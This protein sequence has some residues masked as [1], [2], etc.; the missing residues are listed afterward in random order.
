MKELID[1]DIE[2]FIGRYSIGRDSNPMNQT[3]STHFLRVKVPGGFLTTKQLRGIANLTKKYSRSHAEITNRQSIQ[4]HW[5]DANDAL[6]IFS[7]MEKLG[8]TTDMC[9]QSFKGARHGDARN[10]VCCPVSGI[11]K[12]ELLNGQPLM[13]KLTNFFIGNPDF[14]DLPKKFKFSI[15]GCRSDC[16]HAIINDFS[17]VAVKKREQIGYAALVGGGMGASLPGPRM[18]RSAGIFINPKDA[19]EVAVAAIEIHRDYGNRETKMKARFKW[20]LDD[21]GLQKFLRVLESKLGKSFEKYKGPIFTK[22]NCHYGVQVQKQ[23]AHYHI[24]IPLLGGFL[25]SNQMINLADVVDKYGSGELNFTCKQNIILPNIQDKK[26]VLKHLEDIGF[27]LQVSRLQWSSQ[28]CAS[29]FCGKTKS[30]HAKQ[31]VKEI[32][33]YLES[34]YTK[35][36]LDEAKFAIYTSGCR[37]NCCSNLLSE[38]G[39]RGSLRKNEKGELEQNY[40]ILLQSNCK[41][42]LGLG[43]VIEKVVPAEEIKKK[44]KALLKN[45]F[46]NRKLNEELNQFLKRHTIEEL[47]EYLED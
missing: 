6:E 25:S 11:G 41:E 45:Y 24:N 37:N 7:K 19:F 34:N 5:V 22:N 43:H 30:P 8:F 39:L 42:E 29:F 10:I 21:W 40:D 4:L 27:S 36:L 15:S 26:L 12:D 13:Q 14:L 38:I 46:K 18:A 9:G 1:K 23:K 2:R 35:K 44:L 3:G 33:E 16:T 31:I 32:V 20:L 47:K 17:F 28:A